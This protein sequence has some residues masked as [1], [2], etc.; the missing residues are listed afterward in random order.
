MFSFRT[1]QPG[2]RL[3]TMNS[4]LLTLRPVVVVSAAVHGLN[5]VFRSETAGPRIAQRFR[6]LTFR[7][8][9]TLKNWVNKSRPNSIRVESTELQKSSMSLIS[10][11]IVSRLLRS[12][13]SELN[14]LLSNFMPTPTL[15]LVIRQRRW[16]LTV[17]SPLSSAQLKFVRDGSHGAWTAWKDSSCTNKT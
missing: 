15:T 8:G 17:S 1:F 3:S 14:C 4:L 7:L 12:P 10:P 9:S 2:V 5:R 6:S 13:V 16:L 11:E